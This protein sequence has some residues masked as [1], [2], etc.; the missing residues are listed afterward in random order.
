IEGKMSL[1]TTKVGDCKIASCN[2]REFMIRT[3]ARV[4]VSSLV[5]DHTPNS[6]VPLAP[7]LTNI[8]NA[9]SELKCNEQG[10]WTI[11]TFQD[12]ERSTVSLGRDVEAICYWPSTKYEKRKGTKI[13][14]GEV[15]SI[16][17]MME[18]LQVRTVECDV[19]S[20]R[21]GTEMI[22]RSDLG[23]L[24]TVGSL[25]CDEQSEWLV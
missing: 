3:R 13:L 24:R 12:W 15:C 8:Y 16:D 22:V 1:Q 17:W 25:R 14:L 9:V 10:E 4:N 23:I 7:L 20:C 11:D 5:I 2:E 6:T 19:A 18:F 21:N